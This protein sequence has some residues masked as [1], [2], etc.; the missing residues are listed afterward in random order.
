MEILDENNSS[1]RDERGFESFLLAFFQI[2]GV[3]KDH[4]G[5]EKQKSLSLMA[6]DLWDSANVTQKIT[7]SSSVS[8]DYK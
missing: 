7:D 5:W 2:E 8:G 1:K 6:A 3:G 4:W